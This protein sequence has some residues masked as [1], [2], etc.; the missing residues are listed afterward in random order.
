MKQKAIAALILGAALC[1]RPLM[2][3]NYF[4]RDQ[5][6]PAIGSP[7]TVAPGDVM[8][9]S[10][11]YKIMQ[12]ARLIDAPPGFQAGQY[13]FQAETRKAFKACEHEPSEY[14]VVSGACLIDDDGD[15]TF[16]RG[17]SSDLAGARKLPSPVRYTRALLPPIP[18]GYGLER[19]LLYQGYSKGELHISYREFSDNLARDAFSEEL[20]IPL[21]ETLPVDFAVK[22][23]RLRANAIGPLGLEYELV[24]IQPGSG[25]G[26]DSR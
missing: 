3:E 12:G 13:L 8:V 16:D 4:F 18:S 7:A 2:A 20:T 25:W 22:G 5:V 24:S 19:R 17:A 14:I 1:G 15:G 6:S 9:V 21:G 10:A 23:L 26:E 11:S